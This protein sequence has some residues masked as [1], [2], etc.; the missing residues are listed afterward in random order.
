MID[1]K[2]IPLFISIIIAISLVFV[3]LCGLPIP[4]QFSIWEVFIDCKDLALVGLIFYFWKNK[5]FEFIPDDI[6]HWDTRKVLISFFFVF[7]LLSITIGIGLISG[8]TKVS[9]IENVF[10]AILSTLIDI[11]AL[12]VFSSTTILI[13]EIFF[14]SITIRS[15]SGN[16]SI[17][18]A[19]FIASGIWTLFKLPDVLQLDTVTLSIKS[20]ILVNIFSVGLLCSALRFRFVSIWPGYSLR[21]GFLALSPLMLETLSFESDAF[22]SSNSILFSSEGILISLLILA[23]T[24]F[25]MK[26]AFFTKN[27]QIIKISESKNIP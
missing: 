3:I 25:L 4:Y 24:G 12:F 7:V 8:Y 21:I 13:E 14:R 15:L 17:V 11:P 9:N 20:V 26:S 22:F 18:F 27:G 5:K 16:S 1:K 2:A 6:K 23:Y 19:V 10:T